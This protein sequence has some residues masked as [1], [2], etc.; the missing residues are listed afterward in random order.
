MAPPPFPAVQ[1]WTVLRYGSRHAVSMKTGP[2]PLPQESYMQI[3]ADS[4]RFSQVL[5]FACPQCGSPVASACASTE[6][7]FESTDA[8]WFSPICDCGWTGSVIG[9][10]ALKHWVE[11]W[12]S[13]VG[14]PQM[15]IQEE[16]PMHAS[17][18]E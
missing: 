6:K 1:S 10:Q 12:K 2:A 5:L 7:S 9:V 3:G 4:F 13:P 15:A 8:Y 18:S 17:D 11:A 16:Q 14:K